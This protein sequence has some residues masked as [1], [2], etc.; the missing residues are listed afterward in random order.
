MVLLQSYYTVR[1][2]SAHSIA[3]HKSRTPDL[4]DVGRGL[5]GGRSD[6]LYSPYQ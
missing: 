5:G 2:S 1:T 4:A 6:R 3:P